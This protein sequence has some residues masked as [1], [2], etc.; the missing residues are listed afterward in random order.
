M[1]L[2]VF[3]KEKKKKKVLEKHWVHDHGSYLP[4]CLLPGGCSVPTEQ[5]GNAT[6]AV[7]SALPI[8]P[9]VA[10]LTQTTFSH[11]GKEREAQIT[12]LSK[13]PAQ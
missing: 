8:S 11:G 12:T 10:F 9:G 3:K 6:N 7:P 1:L 13:N 4:P 5:T 2:L